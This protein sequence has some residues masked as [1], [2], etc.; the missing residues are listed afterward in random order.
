MSRGQ[1]THKGFK[2]ES[3][4]ITAARI[5][6]RYGLAATVV[7]A[8]ITAA[9]TTHGFGFM[10]PHLRQSAKVDG[11]PVRIDSV[12]LDTA[13][14]PTLGFVFARPLVLTPPQ[15]VVL[16]SLSPNN[17]RYTSWFTSRGG[18]APYENYVK[19][20]V[21]GNRPYPVRVIY[22]RVNAK[23][24]QPL[25]GTYFLN[26]P[27]GGPGSNLNFEFNLDSPVPTPQLQYMGGDYFKTHT[28]LLRKGESATLEIGSRTTRHYCSYTLQMS[29][30]DG[31]KTVVEN[32]SYHGHPF[33]VSASSARYKLLY[34]GGRLPG[35]TAPFV[36]RNPARFGY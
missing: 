23:C 15:L 32:V 19:L 4:T 16:N 12:T 28:V 35:E 21:E 10:D 13:N 29:V 17:P 34:V 6:G 22:M 33:Q 1:R 11:L 30:V 27:A 9:F 31:D 8:L 36:R 25:Q 7:A 18:V 20:V 3:S 24:T 5:G 26:S 2:R 14:R